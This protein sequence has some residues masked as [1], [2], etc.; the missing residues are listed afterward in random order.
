MSLLT[1]NI[2]NEIIETVQDATQFNAIKEY[3]ADFPLK[4]LNIGI[5][6]LLAVI[7]FLIGIWIIKLVRKA[8]KKSMEKAKAE[9]GVRQFIDS[10]LKIALF[11]LLL[12]LIA[13][14]FGFDAASIVAIVGSAGVTV[15]LALQGSLANLAGG[16]LILFLKPFVVGDY[17][18]DAG[19]GKEGTVTEIHIFYTRLLTFDNQVVVLPNGNLSNNAITNVTKEATRRIDVKVGI[20]YD[21]DIDVAKATL[22]KM[23]NEDESVLQDKEKRVFVDNL[24]PHSVDMIVRFWVK[25]ADYWDTKFRVTENCKKELDKTSVTIPFPQMDVHINQK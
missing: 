6:V 21:S 18:V 3:F 8:V 16:M 13:S 14:Y 22:M 4:A 2:Q 19:T 15:G 11:V 25:G 12:F 9:T 20:S 24:G 7:V 17:I 5:R 23:L 1:S 10:F